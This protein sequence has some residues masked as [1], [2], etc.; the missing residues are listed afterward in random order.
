RAAAP[1]PDAGHEVTELL[2]RVDAALYAAKSRGR[3]RYCL[4]DAALNETLERGRDVERD[5]AGALEAGAV[6]VWFQ[7]IFRGDGR[8]VESFEALLRWR[9]PR[10]G[11]IPPP[12][13]VATAAASGLSDTLLRYILERVCTML[14]TLRE[15]GL[16][17][18]PVAMNV[19]PRELS[20]LAIDDIVLE[21]LAAYGLP[22]A[23]LEIEITE[24]TMLDLR[25]AK[26]PLAALSA[27]GVRVA[28]DDF[29]VGY[30]SLAAL[31]QMRVDRIKIDRC[32]VSCI[33]TSTND[34]VM[35]QAI[36]QIG[37]SLGMDVVAEGVETA[38]DLGVL[39][40]LGCPGLQGYHLGRPMSLQEV[41]RWVGA[42]RVG[43]G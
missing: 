23:L 43:Q 28:L 20:Q 11:L 9:H 21:T 26:A 32:F 40:S 10:H 17:D 38:A 19:S 2:S 42:P 3:N 18:V 15:L 24:E 34:Q 30:S 7:P 12:D 29:G 33:A 36:L 22:P 5:L 14:R 4:F 6:T 39:Q 35:V 25:I 13:I 8:T 16:D 31:R 1:R 41:A 27:A 37:R